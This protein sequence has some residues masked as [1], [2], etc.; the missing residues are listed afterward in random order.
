MHKFLNF[1]AFFEDF[2]TLCSI[3]V[4]CFAWFCYKL[5]IDGAYSFEP[6]AIFGKSAQALAQVSQKLTQKLT[7]A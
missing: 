2:E 5:E 3:A 4:T 6:R 7:Q 1:F